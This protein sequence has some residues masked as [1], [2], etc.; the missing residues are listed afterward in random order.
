MKIKMSALTKLGIK[1]CNMYFK[2]LNNV[3]V[4]IFPEFNRNDSSSHQIPKTLNWRK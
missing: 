3:K 2:R 4:L 1:L